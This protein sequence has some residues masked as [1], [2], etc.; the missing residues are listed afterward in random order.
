MQWGALEESL[1]FWSHYDDAWAA[2]AIDL[3]DTWGAVDH[4]AND[5]K[6]QRARLRAMR[7]RAEQ[8]AIHGALPGDPYRD[9]S[10]VIAW[11]REVLPASPEAMAKKARSSFAAYRAGASGRLDD[12]RAIHD[13]CGRERV[14]CR[15]LEC[16]GIDTPDDLRPW[17]E[18]DEHWNPYAS[19]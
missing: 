9:P 3:G 7:L 8:I 2:S 14:A 15:V 4:Q 11:A 10:T 6:V 18:L 13:A 1:F 5:G 16:D 17:V 12:L 19:E